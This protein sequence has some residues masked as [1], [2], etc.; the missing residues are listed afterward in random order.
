MKLCPLFLFFIRTK[1]LK[2][3]AAELLECFLCCD[4]LKFPTQTRRFCIG[5][6]VH[7]EQL[8]RDCSAIDHHQSS[9]GISY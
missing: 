7:E 2:L 6:R 8:H 4:F 3:Q 1:N 9:S 5:N